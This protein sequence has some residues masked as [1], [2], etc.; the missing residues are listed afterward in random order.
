MKTLSV[1]PWICERG[2]ENYADA[3]ED[4]GR[5]HRCRRWYDLGFFPLQQQFQP[6]HAANMVKAE[7][8]PEVYC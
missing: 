1:K 8:M 3:G 6:I 5:C 2:H 7:E 4:L